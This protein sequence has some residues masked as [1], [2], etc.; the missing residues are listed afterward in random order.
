MQH[1][2]TTFLRILTFVAL[3]SAIQREL[4]NTDKRDWHWIIKQQPG[5]TGVSLKV[6]F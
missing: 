1:V 4:E 6:N 3:I 5:V 2:W